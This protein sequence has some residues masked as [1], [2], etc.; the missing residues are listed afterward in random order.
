MAQLQQE[1]ASTPLNLVYGNNHFEHVDIYLEI[2][3]LFLFLLVMMTKKKK[4]INHDM[5]INNETKAY[6]KKHKGLIRFLK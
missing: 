2:T 5:D 4:T 6:D 3:N 1:N